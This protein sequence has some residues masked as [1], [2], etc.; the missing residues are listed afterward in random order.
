MRLPSAFTRMAGSQSLAMQKN[1]PTILFAAG[2]V[3]SVASTVLACRATLK[4]EAV[5]DD[6]KKN[7][8][9]INAFKYD[10]PTIDDAAYSD[11]DRVHDTAIVYTRAAV[12]VIKL[13]GPA[14]IVGGL[15]IAALTKSHNIL[16][17]R[18]TALS[19]A[20]AAVSA[21]YESYRQKVIDKY[22]EEQDREF[23][24][25]RDVVP[26]EGPD[27]KI[28]DQTV[29]SADG[30]SPYS[31]FFD[32]GSSNWS[33]NAEYNYAFLIHQQNWA[34]DK[35]RAQGHLF[36]NEV[37]DS[38][39]IPRTRA[40]SVVGWSFSG[41]GDNYVDFGIFDGDKQTRAFVNGLEGS[42]LLDFN[43]DGVILDYID[44]EEA[45]VPWQQK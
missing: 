1:A 42:V 2:L 9:V 8:G 11:Q 36:L 5:V 35:L 45:I 17:D 29:V 4:L 6:A 44:P 34:N 7:L 24:Q 10:H 15:S 19:A 31:K 37:Y 26:L 12:D 18:V 28:I 38:L 39:G 43:V 25:S 41:K 32:E 23:R 13:Y 27:G 30:T 21:G 33:K 16:N 14:V 22:G 3:G 40:G 20:Y